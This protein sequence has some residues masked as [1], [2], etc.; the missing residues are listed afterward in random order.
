MT[1]PKI[2]A[3][4]AGTLEDWAAL[5]AA[6]LADPVSYERHRGAMR[7]Q[8]L[9]GGLSFEPSR[10]TPRRIFVTILRA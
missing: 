6:A 1:I 2:C 7:R 4:I 10:A 5:W 8:G 3:F 9:A